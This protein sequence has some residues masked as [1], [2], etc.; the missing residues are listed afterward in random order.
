[1]K[2]ENADDNQKKHMLEI[3]NRLHSEDLDDDILDD[4]GLYFQFTLQISHLVHDSVIDMIKC[5]VTDSDDEDSIPD[6]SERLQNI[7]L[8]DADRVWQCLT[9]EEKQEF[10]TILKD[11]DISQLIP[12]YEPWWCKRLEVE[13]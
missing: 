1:M 13:R 3:L 10:Q 12:E 6:L 4:R 5:T 11:G 2:F 8:N 9:E 7:D